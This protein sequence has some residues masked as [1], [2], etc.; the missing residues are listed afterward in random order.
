MKYNQE[1]FAAAGGLS[2]E[3]LLSSLRAVVNRLDFVAIDFFLAH[4]RE[5]AG[6][7]PLLMLAGDPVRSLLT[8]NDERGPAEHTSESFSAV[9]LRP[10]TATYERP[11]GSDVLAAYA[12]RLAL[13]A[14]TMPNASAR[15][16][17]LCCYLS[18]N[19]ASTSIDDEVAAVKVQTGHPF[20]RAERGQLAGV[21]ISVGKFD[22]AMPILSAMGKAALELELGELVSV[23]S[24]TGRETKVGKAILTALCEPATRASALGFLEFL[25]EH[26]G[27]E[28]VAS[29]R[30]TL[31]L[32]IFE[33]YEYSQDLD[34]KIEGV[35]HPD[36]HLEAMRTHLRGADEHVR[37][38]SNSLVDWVISLNVTTFLPVIAEAIHEREDIADA[39]LAVAGA[40][41]RRS[42]AAGAAELRTTLEFLAENG[43]DLNSLG[44]DG[45]LIKFVAQGEE[46][47]R[48]DRLTVLLSLGLDPDAK[49]EKRRR[50]RAYIVDPLRRAEWD[51]VVRAFTAQRIAH[52]L[53]AGTPSSQPSP[54]RR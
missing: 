20:S 37:S 8:S 15:L 31:A 47:G 28:R 9:L 29:L 17:D 27:M 30:L 51:E 11:P 36:Q 34:A 33:K 5:N 6:K 53:I 41:R 18:V 25:E 10:F 3:I 50:P 54:A 46:R 13:W 4:A 19:Q 32:S 40:F 22:S 26:I 49:D 23:G 24:D 43:R 1:F 42:G 48:L 45:K 39:Q 7:F 52:S 16:T 12:G 21:M 35:I 2:D 44:N 38:A 14:A